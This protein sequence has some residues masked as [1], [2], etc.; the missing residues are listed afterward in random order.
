MTAFGRIKRLMFKN[1]PYITRELRSEEYSSSRNRHASSVGISKDTSC[2]NMCGRPLTK[3]D[4]QENFGFDYH[5]GYGSRHD[6][7]IIKA[8][9]CCDCFDDLLDML[10]YKCKINPVVGNY[11]LVSEDGV[12]LAK[13]PDETQ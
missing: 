5:I 11:D 6:M 13:D 3:W 4:I 7:E 9:F 1:R 12:L 2:C 10:I 8:R